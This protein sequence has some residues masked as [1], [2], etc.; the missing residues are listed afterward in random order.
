MMPRGKR[1]R[2]EVVLIPSTATLA[3]AFEATRVDPKSHDARAAEEDFAARLQR[4]GPVVVEWQ[5]YAWSQGD[6]GIVRFRG[7]KRDLNL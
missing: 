5:G 3:A 6:G 7:R 2:P 4:V 1:S